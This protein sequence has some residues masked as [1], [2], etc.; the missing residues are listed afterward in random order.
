MPSF[1]TRGFRNYTVGGGG[2][3]SP[4]QKPAAPADPHNQGHRLGHEPDS[5]LYPQ[6]PPS[7]A[8]L[9][10]QVTLESSCAVLWVKDPMLRRRQ[11]GSLRWC[12]F[13]PWPENCCVPRVRPR[14]KRKRDPAAAVPEI[15]LK[16]TVLSE[17]PD[18][19]A[20]KA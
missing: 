17:K 4:I 16:A 10:L 20:R 12:G 6:H 3:N 7:V 9:P 13:D 2:P 5:V 1:S 11:L 8:F 19:F 14:K 18:P 15:N